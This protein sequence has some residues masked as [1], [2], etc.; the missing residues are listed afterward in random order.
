MEN[1]LKRL[2]PAS[3]RLECDI[4]EQ[5][6]WAHMDRGL[7]EQALLNL[8]VN[9]RDASPN[10]GTIS[11]T[12]ATRTIERW[13]KEAPLKPCPGDF[14]LITVCDQGQGISPEILSRL[15]EPF[16]TTKGRGQGTG[17]GL[18]TVYS[19]MQ[20]LDGG[21]WVESEV[22]KG[23]SF[24]LCFP[25]SKAEPVDALE[26]AIAPD[27]PLGRGE[28]IALIE[29]DDAVRR[30]TRRI[31]QQ[32]GYEVVE[33][34]G[35]RS[36]AAASDFDGVVLGTQ[37]EFSNSAEAMILARDWLRE[38]HARGVLLL[39]TSMN[40][41]IAEAQIPG[42]SKAEVGI[43]FLAKPFRAAD[44]LLSLRQVLGG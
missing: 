11:I 21:L 15:F 31:L 29:V 7:V 33:L 28:I 27:M 10:G 25:A 36:V 41:G 18:S 6:Q 9:A 19:V 8:V 30:L 37:S 3:L 2:L 13:P 1:L 24:T 20:Q 17:L 38:G 42:T 16:F 44:L 23:S 39:G 43:R 5:P 34:S 26:L 4:P 14:A 32:A 40:E 12:L 35:I 22:G